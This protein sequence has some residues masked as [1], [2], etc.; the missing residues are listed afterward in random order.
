MTQGWYYAISA[1]SLLERIAEPEGVFETMLAACDVPVM[2]VAGE[3]EPRVPQW[4]ALHD[5]MPTAKKEWLVLPGASHDYLGSEQAAH[6][7]R[8]GVRAP[9]DVRALIRARPR[10]PRH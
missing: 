7:Q 3:K 9:V 1:A 4:R 10:Y 5:A 6:R 8:S 2:F